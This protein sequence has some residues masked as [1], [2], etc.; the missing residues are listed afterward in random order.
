MADGYASE[1]RAMTDPRPAR[2]YGRDVTEQALADRPVQMGLRRIGNAGD[3]LAMVVSTLE[4][5]LESVLTKPTPEPAGR[6]R[7]DNVAIQHGDS[8]LVNTLHGHG[9]N[10]E[11]QIMRLHRLLERLEV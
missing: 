5:R 1:A 11:L 6:D 2:D 8:D 7:G 3:E 4:D 9:H 10:T